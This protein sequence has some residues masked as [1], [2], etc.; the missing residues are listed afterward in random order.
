[1]KEEIKDVLDQYEDCI[2]IIVKRIHVGDILYYHIG[3]K[4]GEIEPDRHIGLFQDSILYLEHS[5]DYETIV[6]FRY[7]PRGRSMETYSWSDN[8][9]T[10]ILKN[11]KDCDIIFNDVVI[12]QGQT[13]VFSADS[14]RQMLLYS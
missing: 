10:A 2:Y 1:M 11:N 12:H 7:W 14:H 13:K 8:I 5:A 9:R 6:D 4:Y 3:D